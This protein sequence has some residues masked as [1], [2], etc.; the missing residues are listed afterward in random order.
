[1]KTIYFVRH[2]KSDWDS[3][4]STDH[5]R[6]LST[7]GLRNANALR[8]FLRARGTKIDAALIS[9][10]RRA[11]E[12]FQI[13]NKSSLLTKN[14]NVLSELYDADQEIYL[15]NIH[16][17]PDVFRSVLFLGHNPELESILNLL[18]GIKGTIF[19]KFSTSALAVLSFETDDWNKIHTEVKGTLSL[20]WVPSKIEKR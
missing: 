7:R 19:T 6:G 8:K 4:F 9:D 16:K 17:L 1:M 11:Q 3:P 2:S 12:T 5:E 15:Q 18:L 13:L 10:A 14:V 20:H